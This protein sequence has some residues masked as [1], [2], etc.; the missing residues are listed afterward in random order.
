MRSLGKRGEE[1]GHAKGA[2]LVA[3]AF[4]KQ[5]HLR[6]SLGRMTIS[7]RPVCVLN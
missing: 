3:A 4:T 7:Q 2:T 5:C 6:V 1:A